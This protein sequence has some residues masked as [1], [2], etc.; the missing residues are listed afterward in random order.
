MPAPAPLHWR[1]TVIAG[2]AALLLVGGC[3]QQRSPGYYASGPEST[4]SDARA[5]AQGSSTSRA[6]SQLQLGFG[7]QAKPEPSAESTPAEQADKAAIAGTIRPLR[8]PKTFLGTLPCLQGAPGCASRFTLTLAPDGQWRARSQNLAGAGGTPAP[9]LEQGCWSVTGV[10]P[11]R[12][13]LRSANDNTRASLTFEND[14]LLRVD[15]LNDR[16]PAL[17]YHLTRQ[18]DIDGISELGNASTPGCQQ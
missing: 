6:P 1:P 5:K 12:I 10:Q 15:S 3:A 7:D 13:A 18:P 9:T 17:N 4:L 2:L 11:F 8:E 16:K 14:N